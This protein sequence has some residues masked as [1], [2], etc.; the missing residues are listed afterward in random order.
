MMQTN[1]KLPFQTSR[2]TSTKDATRRWLASMANDYP[3]A[4]TITLKPTYPVKTPC[5]TYYRK[6]TVADCERVARKFQ[7]KLNRSY[8]GRRGADKHGH[9]LKYL[10]ILEGAA[11]NKGL[12]LHYGVGGL[13]KSARLRDFGSH[14]CAA[15]SLVPE[16]NVQYDIKI[17][18]RGWFEYITKETGSTHTDNVLWSLVK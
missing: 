12:H 1:R 4:L 16:I 2:K 15:M 6:L 9:S 11:S 18:D 3:L 14:V 7:Q 13:P 17:A 10:P 5:G 8:F